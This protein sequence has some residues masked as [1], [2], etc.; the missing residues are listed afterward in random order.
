MLPRS[1]NQ[2][3]YRRKRT[4]ER[5]RKGDY[6]KLHIGDTKST[7]FLILTALRALLDIFPSAFRSFAASVLHRWGMSTHSIRPLVE[8]GTCPPW[9]SSFALSPAKSGT[10]TPHMSTSPRAQAVRLIRC[11]FVSLTAPS[12]KMSALFL[13]WFFK[14]LLWHCISLLGSKLQE[15]RYVILWGQRGPIS[16]NIV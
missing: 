3:W 10:W 1:K 11:D 15:V 5:S 14:L 9:R 7:V 16:E 2:R 8:K 13:P 12:D 4:L 6:R